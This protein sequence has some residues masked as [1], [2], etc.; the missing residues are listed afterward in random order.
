MS[1]IQKVR[2]FFMGGAALLAAAFLPGLLC[3]QS[4]V[5]EH[6]MFDGST[7]RSAGSIL[8]P[9]TTGGRFGVRSTGG[10]LSP[11]PPSGRFSG[12]GIIYSPDGAFLGFDSNAG[13]S[14]F[15]AYWEQTPGPMPSEANADMLELRQFKNSYNAAIAEQEPSTDPTQVSAVRPPSAP[16]REAIPRSGVVEA[17]PEQS[18]TDRNAEPFRQPN[19]AQ[20]VWMRGGPR[21]NA[22]AQDGFSIAPGAYQQPN[23]AA[24]AAS[25]ASGAPASSA[26][27]SSSADLGSRFIGGALP[28][29]GQETDAA[30]MPLPISRPPAD[31]NAAIR[32]YLELMLLRSPTVNP[33]SPIQV[34]YANGRA[35]V[36]GIVPAETNRIEAG[37]ILLTD[38][39]VQTVDNK[40]TV[41]PTDMN[42]P[43]PQPFD[44]NLPPQK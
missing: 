4:T 14:R 6:T 38:P 36:R 37:R 35:T 42:A 11:N 9:H 2:T 3:A 26:A 21:G 40:L 44:P 31:P 33:L 15:P 13:K 8:N 7:V 17:F 22:K 20:Q 23:G 43:M 30:S 28:G 5:Q 34:T 27:A 18:V 24:S 19:A 29:A 10:Y 41:L 25:P 1:V 16:Q 12:G 39:R 32:E